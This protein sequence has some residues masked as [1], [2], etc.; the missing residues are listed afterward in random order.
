MKT[1]GEKKQIVIVGG[2]RDFHVMD[3][4]RTVRSVT[5]GASVIPEGNVAGISGPDRLRRKTLF[6]LTLSTLAVRAMRSPLLL[7]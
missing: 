5:P 3:W 1:G 4:M 7:P 2:A 6:L